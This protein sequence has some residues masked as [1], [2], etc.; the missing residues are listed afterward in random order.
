[1][2]YEGEDSNRIDLLYETPTTE[3]NG[4]KVIV[5]VKW[6][7]KNK[8]FDKIKEQLA[9]FENVYFDVPEH[10]NNEDVVIVRHEL[11][12]FSSLS[13]LNQLHI[14][15][16]NVYYPLDFSKLGINSINIPIALRFSLSDGLYP[17][18]NREAIRY[19]EEA[20]T[21]IMEKLKLAANY[22]IEKYN[23]QITDTDDI[24][25]IFSFYSSK[26]RVLQSF[27][28]KS[29]VEIDILGKYATVSFTNPKLKGLKYLTTEGVY[30]SRD[31]LVAEYWKK[32]SYHNKR[33]SEDKW[34]GSYNVYNFNMLKS[35]VALYSGILSKTKK[36]YLREV[37]GRS[38]TAIIK[39][40][41]PYSLFPKGVN[42]T[43]Y[44]NYVNILQLRKYPKSEWRAIV[45]EF[46]DVQDKILAP[47]VKIDDIVI[48][49]TWIDAKKKKPAKNS[50]IVNGQ[51]VRRQKLEGEVNIKILTELERYVDGKNT[52]LVLTT[53]Q[54]KDAHKTPYIIVYGPKEQYETMDKWWKAFN[55][56]FVR[57]AVIGEREL[58]NI[59]K[60][61]LHNWI[62][63]EEFAKGKHKVYRRLAT[64]ILIKRLKSGNSSVF[65]NV[66]KLSGVS[67]K[68]HN[69]VKKLNN[70]L[71]KGYCYHALDVH[72]EDGLIAVA[73]EHNLFDTTILDTYKSVKK[74]LDKLT[75]L[76]PIISHIPRWNNEEEKKMIQAMIDL[77]K[78]HKQRLNWTNYQL[79]LNDDVKETPIE[80][81]EQV[82]QL[83]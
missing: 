5:P 33:F 74:V 21:A 64:S 40:E 28:G 75:F 13:K 24:F 65:N 66:E 58:N 27:D 49:Q 19:T 73:E 80:T 70:Y 35:G 78:Y 52:K 39:K 54:M 76:N 26:T 30:K 62:S 16:D 11:F 51:V 83:I 44:T 34:K 53:I 77:C 4:V 55:K 82:E 20:K 38:S 25:A 79:P 57:F 61:N 32:F 59:S 6:S 9:Y 22:F 15:L 72:V 29:D 23:E 36:D 41:K 2:M 81:E 48:P 43:G 63:M 46:Q 1:M 31:Y 45:K 8:F 12:Q 56:A 50:I 3:R 42:D 47:V 60:I 17:T 18:P 7:D 10:I 68:L 14:C 71:N 37:F 69:D 67:T